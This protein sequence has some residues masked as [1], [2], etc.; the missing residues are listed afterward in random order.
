MYPGIDGFLGTRASLMLDVVFLAMFVVLPVLGWSIYLVKVRRNYRLHK[1]VQVTL[2]VVLL[3][4][5]T[6][7]ELD[8]RVNGWTGRAEPSPYW[9]D[10]TVGNVLAVH[11]VFAVTTAVLW[12]V[13]VTRALRNFP[14]PPLPGPHSAWHKR[15]GWIAAVDMALTSL[16]GWVFYWLAFA[17]R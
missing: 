11:L 5:V 9:S 1:Q 10:G 7:F 16:S 17:A 8:M 14:S 3:A 4:A 15:W 12:I 13:V 2:G 6:L